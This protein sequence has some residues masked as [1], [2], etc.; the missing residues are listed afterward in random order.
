MPA[1]QLRAVALGGAGNGV[2]GGDERVSRQIE[3]CNNGGCQQSRVHGDGVQRNDA[4]VPCSSS[5]WKE[6]RCGC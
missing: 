4:S 3:T 6:V 1:L 2:P 5:H